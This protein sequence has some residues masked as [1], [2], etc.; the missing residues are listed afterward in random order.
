MTS[1]HHPSPLYLS[2]IASESARIYSP[3]S[4]PCCINGDLSRNFD[5]I[6]D[7][8]DGSK[9]GAWQQLSSR[10]DRSD[11]DG[12][13]RRISDTV[14]VAVA[15]LPLSRSRVLQSDPNPMCTFAHVGIRAGERDAVTVLFSYPSRRASPAA[16][17]C[18]T[19]QLRLPASEAAEPSPRAAVHAD[20]SGQLQQ[21]ARRL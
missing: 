16:F 19:M 2:L 15:G 14:A 11:S 10:G 20:H 7:E 18:S 5:R 4:K 9:N 3:N 21:S 17:R 13:I 1:P 8:R 12:L 6:D